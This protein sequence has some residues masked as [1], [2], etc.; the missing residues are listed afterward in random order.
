MVGSFGSSRGFG[1]MSTK[2]LNSIV[3]ITNKNQELEANEESLYR[4]PF[5]LLYDE[6]EYLGEV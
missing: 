3:K 1:S 2:N 6:G 4:S 5:H